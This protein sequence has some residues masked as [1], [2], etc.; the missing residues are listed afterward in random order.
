MPKKH[1]PC[2][3]LRVAWSRRATASSVSCGCH[4]LTMTYEVFEVTLSVAYR[5]T[6][7]SLTLAP[8]E[9]PSFMVCAEP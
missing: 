2:R 8:P 6:V 4:L 1:Q 5:S 3:R 9:D 7:F